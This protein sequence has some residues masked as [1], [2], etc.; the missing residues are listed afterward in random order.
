[1]QSAVYLLQI[2]LSISFLTVCW[3]LCP[4]RQATSSPG[5]CWWLQAPALGRGGAARRCWGDGSRQRRAAGRRMRLRRWPT[6][7]LVLCVHRLTGHAQKDA[8]PSP[9][10]QATPP[11]SAAQAPAT[12]PPSRLTR[13]AAAAALAIPSEPSPG[14][15][16]TSY[17]ANLK[18]ADCLG[19]QS[20]RQRP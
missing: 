19:L 18:S 5:D 9:L 6:S 7:A 20:S 8:L 14:T 3:S 4:P 12:L 1:M 15:Q 17:L 2:A 11:V 16:S 13:G 10:P